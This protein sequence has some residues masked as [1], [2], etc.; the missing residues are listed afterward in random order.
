MFEALLQLRESL[1]KMNLPTGCP[2][3]SDW[4]WWVLEVGEE[5]L[6]PLMLVM[7]ELEGQKYVTVSRVIPMVED[8]RKG[9]KAGNERLQVLGASIDTQ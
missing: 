8:M 2:R 4:D 9:L 3:L 5:V 1:S 6:R 7:V